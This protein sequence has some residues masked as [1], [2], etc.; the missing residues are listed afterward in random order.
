MTP[1]ICQD[2]HDCLPACFASILNVEIDDILNFVGHDGK[3][4]VIPELAPPYCFRGF[5]VQEMQYFA[6]KECGIW[7]TVFE[8]EMSYYLGDETLSKS[9]GAPFD[10]YELLK[11]NGILLGSFYDM[12][13]ACVLWEGRLYNPSRGTWHNSDNF[14]IDTLIVGDWP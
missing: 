13:H 12:R 11:N 4:I 9:F 2:I 6:L 8:N 1:K 10:L 14:E 3:E 5:H 7:T